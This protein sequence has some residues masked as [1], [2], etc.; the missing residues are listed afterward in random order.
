LFWLGVAFSMVLI[1]SEGWKGGEQANLYFLRPL[2]PFFL[3]RFG[4]LF[5]LGHAVFFF[6]PLRFCGLFDKT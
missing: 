4:F 2:F 5:G 6:F 3:F 1:K